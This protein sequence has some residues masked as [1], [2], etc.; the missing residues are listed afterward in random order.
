MRRYSVFLSLFLSLFIPVFSFAQDEIMPLDQV[1]RGM[2]GIGKTVFSGTKVDDFEVEVLGV[3]R[4]IS[5]GRNMILIKMSGGPLAE[6][7]IISGMSGSPGY[8]DG[9]LVGAISAGWLYPKQPIGLVTP[10]EEMMEVWKRKG[11][12]EER[13]SPS[14]KALAAALRNGGEE[15]LG[16]IIPSIEV[17]AFGG[18]SFKRL[19]LPLVLSGF[20]PDVVDRLSPIFE[21]LGFTPIQGGGRIS[22][23]EDEKPE[24]EPGAAVGVEIMRGDIQAYIYG[25]LTYRK[26]NMVLAYG[27]SMTGQGDISFPM[28]T[29]YIYSIFPSIVRSFKIGAVVDVVGVISQDRYSAISGE[30]GKEPEMVPV[31]ITV[32]PAFGSKPRSFRAEVV[33]DRLWLPSMVFSGLW[34]AILSWSMYEEGDWTLSV[35]S[36]VDIRGHKPLIMEELYSGGSSV[37]LLAS[38]D[39]G[40]NLADLV[41]NPFERAQIERISVEVSVLERI[42]VAR[43]ESIRAEKDSVKPGDSLDLYITLRPYLQDE[44]IERVSVP[45]PD[46]VPEGPLEIRVVDGKSAVQLE[47]ARAPMRFSPTN[48]DQLIELLGSMPSANEMVI[49]AFLRKPGVVIKGREMPSVPSSVL[50]VLY[51]SG[52]SGEIS[53]TQGIS[54]SRIRL[55]MPFRVIGARMILVNVSRMAR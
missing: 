11:V 30:I 45:I 37:P 55:K 40:T 14:F 4:N 23:P 54:I 5:P 35:K 38:L 8:I 52:Q 26:G 22:I 36:R 29:V 19:S 18:A 9:K 6:T 13:S 49:D 48:L 28:S 3:M 47:M 17:P 24:L 1:K 21:K 53:M 10:I 16:E 2:K 39:L 42:E 51:G 32:K 12:S 27:H 15:G 31:E 46:D 34:D 33:K 50:S 20:R 7:G 44:R 25:T 41:D 43:I